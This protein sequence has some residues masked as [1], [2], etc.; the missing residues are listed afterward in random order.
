[1]L[2][3]LDGV[4]SRFKPS[5]I[6]ACPVHLVESEALQLPAETGRV[7]N[8]TFTGPKLCKFNTFSSSRVELQQYGDNAIGRHLP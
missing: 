3:M 5:T 8:T 7:A 1:M 6:L 2:R 4:Q